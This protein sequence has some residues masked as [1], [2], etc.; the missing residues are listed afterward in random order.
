MAVRSSHS[1]DAVS[2]HFFGKG[3]RNKKVF[4]SRAVK[5]KKKKSPT[6]NFWRSRDK[7]KHEREEA[8]ESGEVHDECVFGIVPDH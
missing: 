4:Y 6:L 2:F 7:K 8:R 5:K 3:G 1:P